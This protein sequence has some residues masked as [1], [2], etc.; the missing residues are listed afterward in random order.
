MVIITSR[1]MIKNFKYA[2]L[3]IFVIAAVIT[4]TPDPVTQSIV[5]GPMLALYGLS[6]LIAF[7]SE[8]RRKK[9]KKKAEEDLAG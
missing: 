3:A 6:I 7:F 9:E 4:P 8:K 2:F 1:W 5:A